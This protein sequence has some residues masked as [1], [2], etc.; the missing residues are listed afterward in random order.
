MAGIIA[1]NGATGEAD[2]NGALYGLGVAPGASIVAQRIFDGV[3]NY[4]APPS[5]EKLTRDATRA[6][7]VIGSNSWGD[8]TQGRYDISAMEFDELVR[9]ADALTLGDQ[10]YILEFSAGNAGPGTQTIGS[11]AVA[12]N[13]LATG[14]SENDRPDFIIY[15]DGIDVVADFSSRGPCE[16]GRIK[17]DVLAPGTWIAS[18]QSASASDQYAWW[19]ISANYQ[20]QGG[21]SQAGPHA[22]GA[23]A[24]FVQDHRQTHGNATPSPALVKA[25]LINS[26]F[27]LDDSFGTAPVP[28]MDEGWGRVDLTPIFDSS[29]TFDFLDQT[30]PLTNGQVFERQVIL[31]SRDQPLKITLAYTDVPGFPGALPALVNDLDLEVVGPDG[32]LYRGNEFFEGESV[33]NATIADRINNVE[34]VH[35]HEPAPG[36]YIVRVRA[37]NVVQDAR[38][39]TTPIDQDF[40]L[41][42]SSIAAAQG[43]GVIS[44]DRAA[45]TV[46]GQIRII[47][48]DTDLAGQPSASVLVRSTTEPTGET[49]LLN[50]T[51]P[52]GGFTGMI[53][54]ATGS[55]AADGLL[56]IANGDRIDAVYQD[57]SAGTDS[58]ASAVGDLAP[59]VL[60]GV[61]AT[62]SFGQALV[63]WSSGE[64]AN[65]I[66]YV[67]TNPAPGSLD[68]AVTNI[69]M[70]TSHSVA[71]GGLT[72]GRNVLLLC[73]LIG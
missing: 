48:A 3:G 39:D 7:A 38:A 67:G 41:V 32:T 14:A 15:A 47:L 4:E 55:A 34:A 33:A 10:P 68:M 56:Q 62:A 26:A 70:T 51:G 2:E 13:V 50:A 6:G 60:T 49:V 73:G 66:V 65:S 19:P 18:L 44:L 71:L 8:D 20:Y 21:T 35:L 24:V 30:V 59:P 27:D 58:T 36:E 37:Q 23:A 25:A 16:D 53:A 12:K 17:P 57:V 28:N 64:S 9:D 29:L 69:E 45:Y 52:S 72:P 42:I 46:P 31:A 5:Y 43:S 61:A 22:S 40:A 63:T 11:P 54:T 1:G